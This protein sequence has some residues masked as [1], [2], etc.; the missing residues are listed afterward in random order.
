M[1]EKKESVEGSSLPD[2]VERDVDTQ[3]N[4]KRNIDLSGTRYDGLRFL[5]NTLDQTNPAASKLKASLQSFI[6]MYGYDRIVTG[7][8]I[9]KDENGVE[10]PTGQP[11][12]IGIYLKPEQESK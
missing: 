3:N 12:L 10:R 8:A 4:E 9:A 1:I 6:D 7:K 11:G 5:K 2:T